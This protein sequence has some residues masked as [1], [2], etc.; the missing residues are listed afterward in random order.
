LFCHDHAKLE[1][2]PKPGMLEPPSNATAT[3]PP[4]ATPRFSA[5]PLLAVCP[6]PLIAKLATGEARIVIPTDAD[7][8]PS[9]ELATISYEPNA[10]PTGNTTLC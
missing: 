4:C 1:I 10:V 6:P 9:V 5:P 8:E 7:W 3:V 2:D